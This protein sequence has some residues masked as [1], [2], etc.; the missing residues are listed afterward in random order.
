MRPNTAAAPELRLNPADDEAFV[1]I[2]GSWKP[3]VCRPAA[4]QLYLRDRYPAA[5]VQPRQ[6]AGGERP[7]WYVYRDGIWVNTAR[8]EGR[9]AIR[10][11]RATRR[12]SRS[13]SGADPRSSV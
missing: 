9:H 3:S 13:A 10:E 1:R 12:R 5:V 6:V 7:V 8:S 11:G 2:V 4:L